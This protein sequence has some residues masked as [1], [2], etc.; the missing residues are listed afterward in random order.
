VWADL[1]WKW[2]EVTEDGLDPCVSDVTFHCLLLAVPMKVVLAWAKRSSALTNPMGP[3]MNSRACVQNI[4]V[5]SYTF[6]TW[7]DCK[8]KQQTIK[9]SKAL[10][11]DGCVMPPSRE[12]ALCSEA[13]Q[14]LLS[15][16]QT[17]AFGTQ[18]WATTGLVSWAR[19]VFRL[20][21]H[22]WRR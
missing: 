15:S 12:T 20:Q 17:S 11:F 6:C 4:A 9:R 13:V 7:C 19:A 5:I 1:V 3:Q 18:S 10:A 2:L 21:S 22:M 16:V 14:Q 8:S